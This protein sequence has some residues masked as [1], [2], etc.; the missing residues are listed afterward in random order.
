[1]LRR[2]HP[3]PPYDVYARRLPVH[4]P[5]NAPTRLAHAYAP[6]A[7]ELAET[8]LTDIFDFHPLTGEPARI[9]PFE[10]SAVP[11][12]H[13]TEAYGIRVRHGGLTFAY[14]GDTGPCD[15]L[16]ELVSGVDV[17][18]AEATWTDSPKR[19]PGVHLSGKQAGALARRAGV[20]QL[21][22]THVAP[23]NDRDAVLAEAR[24]EFPGAVLVEQGAV[25]DL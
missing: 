25:Y 17:L 20:G 1:V 2:Y 14:T 15:S 23:W 5:E 18:L 24:A 11:V 9:G 19:P 8:D 7:T 4:A 16:E 22:L 10:V 13:P 21:L 6:N 3:E 12:D